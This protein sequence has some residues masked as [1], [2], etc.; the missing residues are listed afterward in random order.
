TLSAAPVTTASFS[1]SR[2]GLGVLTMNGNATLTVSNASGYS[3]EAQSV[4][5]KRLPTCSSSVAPGNAETAFRTSGAITGGGFI[6]SGTG[7]MHVLGG[8][9]AYDGGTWVNQS[10]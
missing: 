6:K 9:S 10:I 7:H 4:R 1:N 2:L 5:L 8:G 3:A